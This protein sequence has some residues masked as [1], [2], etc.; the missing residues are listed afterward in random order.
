MSGPD[1]SDD[2][3]RAN[4]PYVVLTLVGELD[5]AT[6][7]GVRNRISDAI[8]VASE[9]LVLDL[10]QVT[11]IDSL[12]LGVLVQARNLCAA[13]GLALALRAP[14]YR[15]QRILELSGTLVLFTIDDSTGKRP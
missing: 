9:S 6:V 3:Q 13:Y 11:F 7:P 15:V 2:V 14:S 8:A 4:I 1:Q 5:A 12:S 10:A